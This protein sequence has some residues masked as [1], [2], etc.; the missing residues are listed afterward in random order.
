MGVG[1]FLFG[2]S[3]Q[4]GLFGTGQYKATQY[5]VDP[6][7]ANIPGA[8]QL[9]QQYQQGAANSGNRQAPMAQAAQ[10]DAS[11]QAQFRNQQQ[12]LAQQLAAQANGQGPSL[13]QGQL[14]QATDRNLA[15]ALAMGAN[16]RGPGAASALKD[17][18]G[19]RASISQQA[20]GDS[21]NLALNEQMQA[22]NQLGQVLAGARGQDLSL[23]GQN[24][25]FA[26]QTG[27]ANQS[28]NLQQQ[29]LNDNM[30]RFYQ[31]QGLSLA[32]AQQQAAMQLQQ[33]NSANNIA[34]NQIN[35]GAYQNAAAA[36]SGW[37]QRG[38]QA[39]AGALAPGLAGT[40]DAGA[41]QAA[42]LGGAQDWA[43]SVPQLPPGMTLG[44]Y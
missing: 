20:S 14:K 9:G 26:Q 36:R 28:A 5:Q 4:P 1:S 41:G 30:V 7:A 23:A 35:A 10:L 31:A 25:Q 42:A 16:Q 39:A 18:A 44:G 19:Q 34:Y 22:R 21:A 11:Q 13:A 40:A 24:A 8:D 15:Q 29:G 33:L 17:I 12:T 32:E 27:L 37:L 6:N 2:D 43:A 38:F 3:T